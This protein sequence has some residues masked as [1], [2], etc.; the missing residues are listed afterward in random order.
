MLRSRYHT[1]AITGNDITNF[2]QFLR[3]CD[4][5]TRSVESR[6]IKM[7]R[8]KLPSDPAQQERF[9]KRFVKLFRKIYKEEYDGL[10]A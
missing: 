4:D 9:A 7:Q 5:I 6:F 8:V 3:E 1:G 2:S 10:L